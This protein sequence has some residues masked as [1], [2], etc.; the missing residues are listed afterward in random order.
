[1][2]LL[3]FSSQEFTR[4]YFTNADF[5]GPSLDDAGTGLRAETAAFS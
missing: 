2:T 4:S 1:M 3:A 5:K